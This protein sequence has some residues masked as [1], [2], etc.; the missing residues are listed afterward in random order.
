MNFSIIVAFRFKNSFHFDEQAGN[1]RTTAK[2]I[3][4]KLIKA[5][6]Y[7]M[8]AVMSL[9]NNGKIKLLSAELESNSANYTPALGFLTLDFILDA[10]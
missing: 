9:M 5:M 7:T 1:N 3:F 4:L 10:N 6:F 8:P 2:N